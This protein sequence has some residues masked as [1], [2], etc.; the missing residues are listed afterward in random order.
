MEPWVTDMKQGYRTYRYR[1]YSTRYLD[2]HMG[3]G[4]RIYTYE[5]SKVTNMILG[6]TNGN[7]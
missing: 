3:Y 7:W 5:K 4:T 1:T 6:Y 2:K